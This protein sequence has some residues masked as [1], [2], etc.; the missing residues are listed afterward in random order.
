[1]ISVQ[2]PAGQASVKASTVEQYPA[3]PNA[4]GFRSAA[5]DHRERV[6]GVGLDHTGWVVPGE[7]VMLAGRP[8]A[9]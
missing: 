1:M 3:Y 2:Q 9:G 6:F 4:Q 7:L 5:R 8:K